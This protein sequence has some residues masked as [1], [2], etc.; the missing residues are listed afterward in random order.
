M[1]DIETPDNPDEG[2]SWPAGQAPSDINDSARAMM[3]DVSTMARRDAARDILMAEAVSNGLMD[4]QEAEA[5]FP[6]LLRARC[7]KALH[8]FVEGAA[9]RRMISP[10]E[11]IRQSLTKTLMADGMDPAKPFPV[12]A[13]SLYKEGKLITWSEYVAEKPEGSDDWRPLDFEDS[14]PFDPA[15]H[16]RK[17]P[18]IRIDPERVVRVYPIILKSEDR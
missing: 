3:A 9:R 7:S 1:Q 11:Y 16:Y 18:L 2:P 8:G 15:K 12:D 10:S 5:G 13:G 14:E 4:T 17:A 6:E